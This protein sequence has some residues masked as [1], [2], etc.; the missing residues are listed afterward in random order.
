MTRG[1]ITP[2]QISHHL[3]GMGYN[4]FFLGGKEKKN[5]N[6]TGDM[7]WNDL[8]KCLVKT[9]FINRHSVLGTNI[10]TTKPYQIVSDHHRSLFNRH[11]INRSN[12]ESQ[13]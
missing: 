5:F 11:R 1:I 8:C 4:Y 10:R 12:Q 9:W 3:I 7:E 2:L 6:S 13:C